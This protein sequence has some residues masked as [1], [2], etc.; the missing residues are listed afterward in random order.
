MTIDFS[1]AALKE[2]SGAHPVQCSH[3]TSR[4]TKTVGELV[5]PLR[6]SPEHRH[7]YA[8]VLLPLVVFE[9]CSSPPRASPI[10]D[11]MH[12]TAD[13]RYIATEGGAAAVTKNQI[14]AAIEAVL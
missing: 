14:V 2:Y 3:T 4:E 7:V 5:Y 1:T 10:F 6:L 12:A 8:C 13:I 11:S 9:M